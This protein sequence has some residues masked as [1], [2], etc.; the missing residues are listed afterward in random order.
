MKKK[1]IYA[2]CILM[3]FSIVAAFLIPAGRNL[4]TVRFL[5]E[6]MVLQRI[7]LWL[8]K[9]AQENGRYPDD[10]SVFKDERLWEK[11]E[12]LLPYLD[13]S[14]TLYC[15]PDTNR[16]PQNFALLVRPFKEWVFIVFAD[17]SMKIVNQKTGI[18]SSYGGDKSSKP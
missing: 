14:H 17:G 12:A 13:P 9:Y 15:R 18:I 7:G 8:N 5:E 11:K 2:F 6:R 1:I 3:G 10:L 16:P 4:E